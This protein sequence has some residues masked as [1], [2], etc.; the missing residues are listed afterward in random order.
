MYYNRA[1]VLYLRIFFF[2]FFSIIRVPAAGVMNSQPYSVVLRLD[3]SKVA[4]RRKL[5]ATITTS[6]TLLSISNRGVNG[7]IR[8]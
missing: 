1:M 3:G 5:T 4:K 7:K 8:G 2:F 6:T